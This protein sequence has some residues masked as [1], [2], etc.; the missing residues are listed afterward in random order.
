M[1]NCSFTQWSPLA[2]LWGTPDV[3]HNARTQSIPLFCSILFHALKTSTLFATHTHCH[4]Q[5]SAWNATLATWPYCLYANPEKISLRIFHPSDTASSLITADFSAP[6]NSNH[7]FLK[8]IVLVD[9]NA[10]VFLWKLINQVPII[11]ISYSNC[12]PGF[13]NNSLINPQCFHYF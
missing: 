5:L 10:L 8:Y 6:T 12:L 7:I 4:D 13:P 2:S 3:L 1:K 11:Y 9:Q